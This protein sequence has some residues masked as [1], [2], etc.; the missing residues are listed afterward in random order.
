MRPSSVLRDD[1]ESLLAQTLHCDEVFRRATQGAI[2]HAASIC[3]LLKARPLIE[4]ET[5]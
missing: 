4:G 2:T 1:W 3:A 5:L